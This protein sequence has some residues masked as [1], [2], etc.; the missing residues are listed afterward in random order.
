[1]FIIYQQFVEINL[2]KDLK[3]VDYFWVKY[4]TYYIYYCIPCF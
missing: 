1:M 2:T 4:G 3:V